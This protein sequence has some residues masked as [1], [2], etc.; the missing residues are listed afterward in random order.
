MLC[1]LLGIGVWFCHTSV[2]AQDAPG[3]P[4]A[5]ERKNE[6]VIRKTPLDV[7]VLSDPDGNRILSLPGGWPLTV[8]DDF[9]DFLFNNQQNPV[10]PFI[11]RNVSATGTV[12]GQYVE[13]RIQIEISTSGYQPIRIPLGFKEGILLLDEDKTNQPPFYTGAGSAELTVDPQERQYVAIVTP[14]TPQT[15]E[16]EE[17]KESGKSEKPETA[18]QHTLSLLLWFPLAPNGGEEKR[19][20]LSFPQSNSSQFLLEVPKSNINVSVTRGYLFEQQENAERQSTLLGIRGLRT[21]TEITWKRRAD[22]IVDDRPV[23]LVERAAMDVRLDARST[24][25]DV[26][27]PVSSATSSFDQLQIR[28]PQGCTLDREKTDRYAVTGNYSVGEVNEDSVLTIRFPQKTT[29]P[30]SLHLRAVQQFEED[31]SDFRREL[32]GFEVLGAELQTGFLTVS[33]L[34]SE[35]TLHWEQVR[36]IRRAEGSSASAVPASDIRT[37]FEFTSQLFQLRVQAASPHTRINVKPDYQFRISRGV[38]TMNARLSYTV[39][40]FKA[41]VL[42][43][44]LPDSRWHWE[45]GASSIVDAAGVELDESSVLMIPL[46]RSPTEGTFDIEFRAYRTIDAEDEQKYQLILPIPRPLQVN[47]DAP[48]TVTI[49]P[50]HNV[51]V[52]PIEE[53]S[54]TSERR[55]R[56]LIR[57]TRRTMPA[58]RIDLTDTQQEPF[59]YHAEV[60]DA[61]FVADLIFHQQKISATMQTNVQLFEE[62]NRVTQTIFYNAAY[63][64]VDRV[65]VLLPQSLDKSGEVQVQLGSRTLELRDTI[66][67]PRESVP[68]NWVRKLVIL[69]EPAFQFQLTFQYP[70][71]PIVVA[72]DDT[73][74]FSLSLICPAEVPVTEHNIRFSMPPG[75]KVDLQNESRVLWEPF[76]EPHRPSLNVTESF[77][78]VQA[79]TKIALFVSAS[80]RND[81]GTTIV[82]RAWLQTWLTG[83]IRADRATYLLRS[84]N[85]S[86]TLE[87]PPDSMR[88]YPVTVY[89]ERQP[90][91]PNISL[92]RMLT[93]PIQP[94]QYNRLIEVSVD[95]RYSF[96]TSDFEVPIILPSFAKETLV[97][98]QFW[99]VIIQQNKHIIG[100]PAGWT[101]EYDWSWNGLFWRRVP[102]IRKSDIGFEPDSTDIE[103]I[104]SESSQY[105]FSHLQ[106][107]SRVTLY[108]V[109]RSLIIFGSSSLALFIGL[110]LIYIPQSRYAGSLFGLGVA[111]LAV[112]FYHPPLV[113]LMLQA[114]VFGV[115]LA[116]G[117]GYVY[118]I[119]HRQKQWIPPAFPM[120]DDVSQSYLTP[121][122]ASQT[123]HEVIM[124]E[125]SAS[126]ELSVVNNRNGVPPNG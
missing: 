87:L 68:D 2:S 99:Q 72:D 15:V 29:G 27:L 121:V 122:P 44:M 10:P 5:P 40:G 95:Y 8:A 104:I 103:A 48:A 24:V 91:Q 39:S 80:E 106:P 74:P 36:G 69:P 77:R 4:S 126:K 65:H 6:P 94:E 83:T 56:G 12:V 90:I 102:S 78:S 112:L 63:A 82:E 3:L 57:Q 101:L 33:V 76:R 115:F 31:T 71:P 119:F 13:T 47:W 62:N 22:E 114:A 84:T 9:H 30:V 116:L 61:E 45:F 49:A 54:V 111:L 46:L 79:P 23:L 7:I 34:P 105:V 41:G 107:A 85:D 93:I 97:Q 96:N 28:L 64:L 55:T 81:S 125:E 86:I 16:T 66:S 109:N 70:P 17:S 124:D 11:I 42:Y 113:L 92:A 123:V 120:F 32:A 20:S 58:I 110:V 35:M 108:I 37:R 43:L 18:Q 50:V 21:D 75:F 19:L 73:V 117:T 67:S 98:H 26:V 100:S 38:I 51:E 89:V 14:S 1:C 60:S 118:R 88:E 52:L 53:S 59:F 25:Y